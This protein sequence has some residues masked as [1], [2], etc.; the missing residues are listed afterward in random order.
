MHDPHTLT[1]QAG[2]RATALRLVLK[3]ARVATWGVA[4]KSAT[5]TSD[6]AQLLVEV[7]G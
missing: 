5:R 7:S 4:A 2:L 6:L 1:L 3:V